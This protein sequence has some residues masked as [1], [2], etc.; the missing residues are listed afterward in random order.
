MPS[1]VG[2]KA[3]CSWWGG[4]ELGRRLV[5]LIFVIAFGR[6]EVRSNF[7]YV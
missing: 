1:C 4:V 2:F 7:C 3:D 6:N 5:L